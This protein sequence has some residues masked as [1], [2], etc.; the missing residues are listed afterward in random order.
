[1]KRTGR[2]RYSLKESVIGV[3][4]RLRAAAA[5][6]GGTDEVE[7]LTRERARLARVQA[8][9]HELKNAIAR[10]EFLPAAAVADRWDSMC[11]LIRNR[12]MAIPSQL[13]TDLPHLTRHDLDV[14]DRLI[15]DALSALADEI[16]KEGGEQ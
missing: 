2:G 7:S 5:G 12:M 8:D 16:D 11:L 14:I 13:P 3:L 4:R 15:R 9:G 10:G 1:M 6:R